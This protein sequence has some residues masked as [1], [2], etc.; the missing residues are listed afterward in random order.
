LTQTV[1]VKKALPSDTWTAQHKTTGFWN[2]QKY[3]HTRTQTHKHTHTR[4]E[5]F[6]AYQ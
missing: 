6:T 2:T 5:W 1:L 3:T 4:N